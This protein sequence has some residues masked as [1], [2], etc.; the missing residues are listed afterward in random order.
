MNNREEINKRVDTAVRRFPV[1][2]LNAVK[3]GFKNVFE[4]LITAVG[5]IKPDK[6]EYV[7]DIVLDLFLLAVGKR[8]YALSDKQFTPVRLE[9]L[10]EKLLPLVPE[11]IA[12][13]PS[14][15]IGKLFNAGENLREK[16]Y[17]FFN[18]LVGWFKWVTPLYINSNK[19]FLHIPDC[20]TFWTI[21]NRMRL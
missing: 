21:I 2:D 13:N 8:H 6:V 11:I 7:F 20:V 1:L 18:K 15:F 9:L 10:F 5:K 19:L 14:K 16:S 12:E 3:H 17:D 4:P